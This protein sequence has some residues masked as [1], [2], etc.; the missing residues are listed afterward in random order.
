MEKAE[1]RRLV[2]ELALEFYRLRYVETHQGEWGSIEEYER[3]TDPAYIKGRFDAHAGTR[4][5]NRYIRMAESA[6]R[7]MEKNIGCFMPIASA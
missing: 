5:Y 1:Q 6:L 3:M 7:I 4:R 2:Y